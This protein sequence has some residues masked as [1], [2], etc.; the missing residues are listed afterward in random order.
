MRER[1]YYPK[2]GKYYEVKARTLK[3]TIVWE[4]K[5]TK[6]KSISFSCLATHQEENMLQSERSLNHKIPDVGILKKPFDGVAIHDA[7]TVIP[8][9]F[10]QPRETRI[11]EIEL[12][13]FIAERENSHGRRS[14]TIERAAMI[15]KL[16]R[17]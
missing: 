14:L 5:L 11:Y 9:I 15:G 12:R 1:D 8:I 13:S 10:Y 17:V 6:T 4:A 3:R 16:I 7:Y 2:L